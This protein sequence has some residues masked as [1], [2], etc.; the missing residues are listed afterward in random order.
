VSG[1]ILQMQTSIDGYV[2]SSVPGSRWQQWN[3]GSDWPWTPDL[4][5]YFNSV[6]AN[7]GGIVLSRPMINQGYLSHWR[8]TADQHPGDPDYDFARRITRLPKYVLS[9]S[10]RPVDTWPNTAVLSGDFAQTV[11]QAHQLAGGDLICFGGAG[12][13]KALLQRNLVDELQLFINPGIAG[14]G[15]QIFDETLASTRFHAID[16][17]TYACGMIVTRWAVVL[18]R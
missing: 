12:F 18:A 3:W 15:T 7:A 2:E 13:A 6:V 1:L 17:A 16:A 9:R 4:R 5:G 11:G 10:R 8:Q 14:A